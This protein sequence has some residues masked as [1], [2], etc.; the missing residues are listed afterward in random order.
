MRRIYQSKHRTL[1]TAISKYMGDRAA[2]IGDKSGLHL[3]LNVK[4]RNSDELLQLAELC[5][6]RIYSPRKHWT[7]QADY[8]SS[9]VMLGFGGLAE[10]EIE[11]GIRLLSRA[12]F[13]DAAKR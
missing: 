1:I 11:E 13:P 12:W 5:G 3:L 10:A 9:Y 4:D 7:C 8:P 2:I 6:C